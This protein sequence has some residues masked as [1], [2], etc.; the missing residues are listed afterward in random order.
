MAEIILDVHDSVF[1]VDLGCSFDVIPKP[2]LED[3]LKEMTNPEFIEK[4][5]NELK[6]LEEVA[7]G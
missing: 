2:T 7:S 3:L 4:F 6:K 5:K 1:V